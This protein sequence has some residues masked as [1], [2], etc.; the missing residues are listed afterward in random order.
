MAQKLNDPKMLIF[1]LGAAILFL[2]FALLSFIGETRTLVFYYSEG[3]PHCK[4]VMNSIQFS[5]L[6]RPIIYREVYVD[7]RNYE[8]FLNLAKRLKIDTLRV[9]ALYDPRLDKLLIGD[10]EIIKHLEKNQR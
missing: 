3:C 7:E 1:S 2:L 5:K 9:P 10:R 8:E 4:E 6:R